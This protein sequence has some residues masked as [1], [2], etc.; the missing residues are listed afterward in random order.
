MFDLIKH[1]VNDFIEDDCPSMAAALAY[2]T[3]FSLPPLLLIVIGVAGAFFGAEAVSNEIQRQTGE[4][5]GKGP[6]T[7]MQTMLRG[8]QQQTGGSWWQAGIGLIVLLFGAT[9]AFAQLQAALNRAW[10][11]KTDPAASTTQTIRQFLG[12]RLLSFG[13]ILVLGFLLLV[14]LVISAALAAM[15][16]W[17]EAAMGEAT[18][19]ILHVLNLIVAYLIVAALFAA[20]FKYLPD[21]KIAWRDVIEGAMLTAALFTAGKFLLG[22]YLGASDV[23]ATYGTAGSLILILLWVYY[24]SMIVLLGAEFT[25][26]WAM[27]RGRWARPEEGAVQSEPL[28]QT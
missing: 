20:M 6:A 13:L 14:S 12:K 19:P 1:T 17:L 27:R 8:A 4:M 24:N 2:Y 18:A 23:G 28:A 15:G 3:V 21:A 26:A 5:I 10:N 9:T 22:F 11:V 7:E 25:Q 16:A